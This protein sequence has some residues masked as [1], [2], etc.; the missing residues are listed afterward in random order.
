[1]KKTSASTPGEL[2]YKHHVRVRYGECDPSGV[3]YH[4]NYLVW[5]HDARDAMLT[6]LGIS[7][8]AINALGY[9]FPIV[10]ARC[11]Y[12]RSARY[13]DRLVVVARFRPEAIARMSFS[14]DIIDESSH[15]LLASGN[16]VVVII[17]Q[18]SRIMLRPPPELMK[19]IK[20]TG[21]FIETSTAGSKK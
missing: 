17:D 18:A 4:P 10:D 5:F 8:A 7:L 21:L 20:G 14:F 19:L 9:Q 13:D 11:R 1:M 2:E 6:D 3:A 12:M 15:A 16:T